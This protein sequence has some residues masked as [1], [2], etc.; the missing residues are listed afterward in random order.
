MI[1]DKNKHAVIKVGGGYEPLG[2]F[3]DRNYQKISRKLAY[4]MSNKGRNLNELMEDKK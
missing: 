4:E 1:Q 3:I 2:G